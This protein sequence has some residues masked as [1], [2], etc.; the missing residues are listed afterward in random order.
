MMMTISGK[1]QLNLLAVLKKNIK[2]HLS[3][4]SKKPNQPGSS[5]FFFDNSTTALVLKRYVH[6]VFVFPIL[7]SLLRIYSFVT[8]S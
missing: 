7:P 8:T 2:L 3:A 1:E 4:L 5:D 6:N